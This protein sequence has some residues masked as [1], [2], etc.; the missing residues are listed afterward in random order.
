MNKY[1]IPIFLFALS[2]SDNSNYK[3]YKSQKQRKMGKI[4]I[5]DI[6]NIKRKVTSQ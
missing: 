6:K 2:I 3:Q 1:Y 5:I 4:L